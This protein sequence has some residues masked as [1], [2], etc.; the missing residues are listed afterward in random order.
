MD[1]TSRDPLVERLG[2]HA[3]WIQRLARSVVADAGLAEDLVQDTWVAALVHG[4]ET[5]RDLRPWLRRVLVNFANKAKRRPAREVPSREVEHGAEPSPEELSARLDSERLLTEELAAI[6]EP[7]RSTLILHFYEGL[8]PTDIANRH[9]L[10]AGT[11][12]WRLKRGL[13][14]MRERLDARHDGDRRTWGLALLPLTRPRLAAPNGASSTATLTGALTMS[15][16]L[17]IAAATGTFLAVSIGLYV[18]PPTW[19]SA[20]S[21]PAPVEP[22]YQPVED[23]RSAAPDVVP[24]TAPEERGARRAIATR[25]PA[26]APVAAP[27]ETALAPATLELTLVDENDYPLPDVPVVLPDRPE[28]PVHSASDGSVRFDV[29]L[30]SPSQVAV[31]ARAPGR[32]P[33]RGDVVLAPGET[34]SL[35]RVT[36]AS[37]GA[38]R[39]RVVD[40]E[41]LGIPDATVVWVDGTI[42]PKQMRSTR[43]REPEPS[44]PMDTTDE[45]GSF[46]LDGLPAGSVRLFACAAGKTPIYTGSIEVRS[47]EEAL[48]Y[49]IR[50]EPLMPKNRILVAVEDPT[51]KRVPGA[52]LRFQH[53]SK[54]AG[55]GLGSSA[56]AGPDGTY[57]FLLH[58]DALLWITASD[59]D[60]RYAPAAAY[61]VATGSL[62]PLVLT[63]DELR[64]VDLA[65]VDGTGEPVTR[66][67]V[68][69]VSPDGRLQHESIPLEERADGLTSIGVPDREYLLR[70]RAPL[71]REL[72]A[73]PY[74]PQ[75]LDDVLTLALE[76]SP[77]I[78]G[79]VRGPE[80]PLEGARVTLHQAVSDDTR[81]VLNGFR[82]LMENPALDEVDSEEDGRFVLTVRKGGTYYVQAESSSF[83]PAFAGPFAVASNASHAPIEIRLD[84]AGSIEGVVTLRDGSDAEGTIVGVSRGDGRPRTTRAGAK[85]RFRFGDLSPGS[86]SVTT[87]ESEISPNTKTTSVSS[88]SGIVS[89]DEEIEWNCEVYAGETT[90]Y[91]LA[92]GGEAKGSGIGITGRVTIRGADA[93]PWVVGISKR[94]SL[95][96]AADSPQDPTDANGRFALESDKTGPRYLVFRAAWKQEVE[97]YL[98]VPI[99]VVPDMD[100]V[101]IDLALGSLEVTG[102]PV[103]SGNDMPP[104]LY[105]WEDDDGRMMFSELRPD[106]D[107]VA[108]L[109]HVPAGRAHLIEPAPPYDDPHK[110]KRLL[111]VTVPRNGTASVALPD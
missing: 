28:D 74:G 63:L 60:G 58:D 72:E 104:V 59:P 1:E 44:T 34:S 22:P 75:V 67:E 82:C 102:V 94:D 79:I 17:K 105:F 68:E 37:G 69:V 64:A 36:L 111:E 50:M 100:P 49:E 95:L 93:L 15:T 31:V 70:I 109:V 54:K 97:Q 5:S 21:E 91:E 38:I 6:S 87:N 52:E 10:P 23:L 108:R 56:E 77:G 57:E 3:S 89:F 12:R 13:E 92:V 30:E 11:V 42:H 103:P 39:G 20:A 51:G 33:Y 88:G 9:G 80:G 71:Y 84:R 78:S 48:G 81:Y 25:E 45:E 96:R 83:A 8:Q 19:L 62:D 32:V 106:P 4:P 2:A 55:F 53:D 99:D 76:S 16:T 101:E 61:G 35:G 66:Y 43:F 40:T 27:V 18:A 29:G 107:G 73:G 90:W 65:I 24:E 41:G 47:G 14:L 86:W 98:Y 85:G 110:M 46:A 26:P 7:F